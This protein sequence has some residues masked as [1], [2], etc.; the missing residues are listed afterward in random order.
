MMPPA[1]LR[2]GGSAPSAARVRAAKAR[3]MSFPNQLSDPKPIR[4]VLTSSG[5]RLTVLLLMCLAPRVWRAHQLESICDDGAFHITKAQQ[6]E[7]HE[8][9]FA[10][11]G[12]D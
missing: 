3:T 1:H 7:R 11:D 10:H 2:H 4:L 9:R 12:Y 8:A 6:L 5:A